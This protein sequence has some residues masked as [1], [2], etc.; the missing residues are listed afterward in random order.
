MPLPHE[1]RSDSKR[2][3]ESNEPDIREKRDDG[4]TPLH[5]SENRID[6]LEDVL[7]LD[8]HDALAREM[9]GEDVEDDLHV[10]V[11]VQV[12]VVLPE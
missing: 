11:G 6:R 7:L 1:E 12:A 2:I 8:I 3:A 10:A 5:L 4:V 9:V